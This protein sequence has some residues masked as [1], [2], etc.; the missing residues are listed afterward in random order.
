MNRFFGTTKPT[1][2][3][4]LTDAISST[5]ARADTADVKIRKLDA[6]LARYRDQMSKMRDG[7]SKVLVT[8][9]LASHRI[10]PHP[11]CHAKYPKNAIKQRAMR[12]LK[13]RKLYEGQR[14]TLMQQAFN[15]EQA[16]MATENLKNTAATIDAMQ[17]ANTALKKQYKTVSVD[18]I[19]RMQDEMED[20]LAQASDLQDILGRS[21]G[22]P[23][24]I[25]EADLEAELEALGDEL[26][27]D[28]EE[29]PAYLQDTADISLPS[30]SGLV[31][32]THADPL[33]GSASA[34][35]P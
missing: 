11:Q 5:D 6:E 34:A 26:L 17:V 12:V 30:T 18:K 22:L 10:P 33:P 32:P 20:L 31:D 1:A 15:M 9:S 16:Q 2:R 24:D 7:P 19:E 35:T 25:D 29:V 27:M 21:Y 13:Q 28:D 3:P 14:D 8:F 4:T 23:D